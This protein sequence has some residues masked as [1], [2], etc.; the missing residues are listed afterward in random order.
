[1]IRL[2]AGAAG[3]AL[4]PVEVVLDADAPPGWDE[5][6]DSRRSRQR[7]TQRERIVRATAR[8]AVAGGF[9]ALSI[10]AISGAAGVS[11]QTFYE[12]FGG[13]RD[14]F[15]AAFDELGEEALA[16]SVSAFVAQSDPVQGVGAGLRALLEHIARNELF[17]R[18]A[19]YELPTAGP[20]ALDR[21]DAMLDSFTA[22]LQEGDAPQSLGAPPRA[23]RE[24]VAAGI[25]AT[26]QYE[27]EHGRRTQ[28]PEIAPQIVRLAL[29]PAGWR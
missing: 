1:V 29:T 10:P 25:W 28:L 22:F 26:I 27:I 18:L 5:P 15:L 16:L 21:A 2:A 17:A 12:H 23:I 19:F 13:K 14:A 4:E 11:N 20:P 7:L 3:R 6:P 24:A 8:V 9:E